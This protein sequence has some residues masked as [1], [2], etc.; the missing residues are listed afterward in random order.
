VIKKNPQYFGGNVE[1]KPGGGGN[2][3]TRIN[4]EA[5]NSASRRTAEELKSNILDERP[6]QERVDT[7]GGE[8]KGPAVKG[9]DEKKLEQLQRRNVGGK[10]KKVVASSSQGAVST[11]GVGAGIAAGEAKTK[12]DAAKR[13][14]GLAEARKKA[15]AEADAKKAKAEKA[16]E[17]A[18]SINTER[19]VNFG[20]KK[21]GAVKKYAAGGAIKASKMGAVKT[22][23]PTMRSASSRADGIA[24][25]GKT[26]A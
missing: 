23:K 1:N 25:R 19:S 11:T 10:K 21:G 22:A 4:T 15:Q 7:S 5:P 14:A 12:S 8:Y 26:R 20:M 3:G 17:R 6:K 9:V 13:E 16:R 18:H 24:I 2:V